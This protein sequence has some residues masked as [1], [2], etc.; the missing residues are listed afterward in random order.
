M[1][2]ILQNY[3]FEQE[4]QSFC[5][6]ILLFLYKISIFA[7]NSFLPKFLS[8]KKSLLLAI[9]AIALLGA[10]S[11]NTDIDTI[12]YATLSCRMQGLVDGSA[13]CESWWGEKEQ[14]CVYRAEDWQ[15]AIMDLTSGAG[16]ASAKFGGNIAG[17]SLGYYAVC[18]ASA[19]GAIR[20]N[21]DVRI[22]VE[23]NN[24]FF[25][26]ENSSIAAPQIGTGDESLTFKSLFGALKLNA[27]GLT[28][29]TLVSV[30]IPNKEC[31]LHGEFGY[32]F[33]H[34]TMFGYDVKYNV[35]RELSSPMDMSATRSVYVAMPAGEYESVEL[36]MRDNSEKQMLYVANDVHIKRGEVTSVDGVSAE[37]PCLVG[38]W[39][40]KSFCG[41][42]A[43]ADL[44]IEFESNGVFTILQRTDGVG[45]KEY[46]GTY[47]LDNNSSIV[48]GVYSDG[49]SWSSSYKVSLNENMEL[50]MENTADAS[51]VTIYEWAEMP[52]I[53]AEQSISLVCGDDVKPL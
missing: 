1:I 40:I 45:Y 26:G 8:M 48:S 25:A 9:C 13:K 3:L 35:T 30:A 14:I 22:M 2:L 23:P 53:V 18:P 43:E 32:N 15:P 6:K 52:E 50:V 21:G 34:G 33:K 24:I 7:Q 31:G 44:Y 39:H 27:E 17:T 46:K 5:A 12:K 47:E 11:C 20:S 49:E 28:S 16:G 19:V 29:V 37:L 51:E 38:C 4:K 10:S 41:A 36:V 42:P